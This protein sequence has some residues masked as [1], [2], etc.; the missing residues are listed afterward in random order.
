VR[1][2]ILTLFPKFFDNV[3]SESIPGRAERF[4]K[5]AYTVHNL[6]DY[7]DD[8][9]RKAD[10]Y[11]YGGGAGML[12]KPEPLFKALTA[13]TA[14]LPKRP[15]IIYPSPQ[16]ETFAQPT[17]M[18]LAEQEH[19]IFICGHYKGIDQRVI[20]RWVDRQY[21]LGDYVVSSGEVATAVIIDA[22]VRLLPGVLGDFDSAKSD[23][24]S[25]GGYD[26]PHYTRPEEIAGMSVPG[27]LLSGHQ[28]NIEIWRR[29]GS[30]L[31]RRKRNRETEFNTK[32]A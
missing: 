4:G 2:E 12:L 28:R 26:S 25:S 24:F 20:E 19:L 23:S 3:L 5:V 18:E 7:S 17:A 32:Q 21:S 31:L 15:L 30:E 8:P 10:D 11:L 27:V 9:H 29:I 6:R 16:G 13:I 22:V 14:D 1:I